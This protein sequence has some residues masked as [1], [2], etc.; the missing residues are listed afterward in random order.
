MTVTVKALRPLSEKIGGAKIEI[1]WSCGTVEDLLRHL[2]E[3]RWA[4]FEKELKEEDGSLAYLFSVNGKVQRDLSA[5]IRD[6]DEV[7]IFTPLGGG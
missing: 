5:V 1:E 2:A 6:G 3:N 7:Y 4:E